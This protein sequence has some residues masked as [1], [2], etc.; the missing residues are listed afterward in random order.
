MR[1]PYPIVLDTLTGILARYMTP[2]AARRFAAMFADN[3]LEGVYS[4]G[5]Q[6]FPRTLREIREG[7]V[8]PAITEPELVLSLGALEVMDGRFGVGALVADAAMAR[9]IALAEQYGLGCV[10]LRDNNHSQRLGRYALQAS[11]VGMMGICW[12]N[13]I[14]NMPAWGFTAPCIGNNPFCL[15]LP[16][17]GGALLLD[18]S[19]SQYAYGKL[20]VAAA[21]GELLPTEGGWDASGTLTRDPGAILA[22]RRILPMG[23]WKGSGLAIALDIAAAALSMG[24]TTA[25]IGRRFNTENALSQVFLAL[26]LPS[27]EKEIERMV[28]DTIAYLCAAGGEADVEPHIPGDALA[29]TRETN[30]REGLPL[31]EALWAGILQEVEQGE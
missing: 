27:D 22:T 3:T 24:H 17:E 9:A 15:S 7:L 23:Y 29:Q 4:H 11:S 21:A 6:R 14:A 5:V 1:V 30:A 16:R 26:K 18:T 31:D 20:E 13:A 12:C 2:D 8:N 28:Q 19:M 10:A 25:E